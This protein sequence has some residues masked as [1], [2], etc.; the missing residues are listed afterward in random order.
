MIVFPTA[1][2]N[3]GLRVLRRRAD[4]YHDLS[5]IMVPV[6]WCDVLEVV[7]G[8][9]ENHTLSV[10]GANVPECDIEQNLVMKAVRA[11]EAH[12]GHALPPLDF[13]LEKVIPFGAGLG[14]GSADASYTLIAVNELLGLGIEPVV[15]AS[16]AARVGA[17]CAFFVMNY[18]TGLPQLAEGI[19]DILRPVEIPALAGMYIAIAKPA[20][21]AISTREAYAGIKPQELAEGTSL[22][23]DAL[24]PATTWQSSGLRNDFELSIFPTHPEIESL[25][26]HFLRS[27]AVYS[28]MSGS[29]AA[30]FGLFESE[31]DAADSLAGL[32]DCQTWSGK[33]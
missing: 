24:C 23:S 25:K 8:H 21:A 11:L 26:R 32:H 17:D 7:P 20:A 3:L 16:V 4:G 12:L 33:L 1:K 22:E 6:G 5:T 31:G 19:G 14:G 9:S 18:Y 29:G 28:A 2:I 13:Y 15:L 30:V 27:G 10:G